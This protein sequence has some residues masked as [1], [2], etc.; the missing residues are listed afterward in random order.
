MRKDMRK[1]SF[2]LCFLLVITMVFYGCQS[3]A[4]QAASE[5]DQVQTASSEEPEKETEGD[6]QEEDTGNTEKNRKQSRNILTKLM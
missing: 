3:S 4:A 1:K 2:L 6:S 5:E